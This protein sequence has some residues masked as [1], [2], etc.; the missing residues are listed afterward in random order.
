VRVITSARSH[1]QAQ[2]GWSAHELEELMR[3]YAAYACR[4]KLTWAT[5][6]T[7]L[8][9]PQFFL[10]GPEPEAECL[11]AI[12]RV[13]G[14]YVLEDGAAHVLC[15]SRDRPEVVKRAQS[16]LACRSKPSLLLRIVLPFG[17]ARAFFDEKVEPLIPD[18]VELFLRLPAIV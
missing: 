7:E 15:E 13:G 8:D 17:A 3:L 11:T 6:V 9:D 5:A 12:S 16:A 10:V 2:H 18:S 14:R 4:R 1:P